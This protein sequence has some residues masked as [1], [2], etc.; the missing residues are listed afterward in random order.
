MAWMCFVGRSFSVQRPLEALLGAEATESH[1]ASVAV[2][3]P[4]VAGQ[5]AVPLR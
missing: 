5:P 1:V 2:I 3:E 4:E